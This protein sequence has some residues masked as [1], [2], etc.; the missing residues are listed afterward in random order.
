[1]TAFLSA[2]TPHGFTITCND[3]CFAYGG[4]PS[5]CICSGLNQGVG[6]DRAQ[7]NVRHPFHEIKILFQINFPHH[8]DLR[9]HNLR[10]KADQ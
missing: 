4:G 6:H 5:P 7:A 1:M 8:T 2:R 9:R 3:S 10:K